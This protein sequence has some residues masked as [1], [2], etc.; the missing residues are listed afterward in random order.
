MNSSFRVHRSSFVLLS[1]SFLNYNHAAIRAWN[2]PADHQQIIL[3]VD[4]CHCQSFDRDPLVAH[5][6]G[7]PRAFDNP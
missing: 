4:T 5:V 6:A 7:R 1:I 2:R 3:R